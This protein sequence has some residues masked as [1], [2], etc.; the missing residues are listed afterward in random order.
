MASKATADLFSCEEC[1]YKTNKE[2]KFRRH[3][4]TYH[5]FMSPK[6]L[7]WK[8]CKRCNAE[9]TTKTDFA[10]HKGCMIP[11]TV[12]DCTSTFA[13]F[14]DLTRHVRLAHKAKLNELLSCPTEG[15]KFTSKSDAGL[16][17]HV[18]RMHKRRASERQFTTEPTQG[19]AAKENQKPAEQATASTLE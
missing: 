15:C 4:R 5:C 2:A 7:S 8:K 16:H 14:V 17:V 3:V 1:S 19:D 10:E 6:D 13:A 12:V 9:F 11:C 18:G